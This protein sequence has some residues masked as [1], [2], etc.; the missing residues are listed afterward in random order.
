MT[1]K[2]NASALLSLLTVFVPLSAVAQSQELEQDPIKYFGIHGGINNVKSWDAQVDFGGPKVDAALVLDRGAHLGF[3]L[4]RKYT[5]ARY[6]LEYQYGRIEI[7]R[8][9]VA[10]LV[11][12]QSANGSYHVATVNALRYRPVNA[13]LSVYA[14]VGVGFAR[15]S[16]PDLSVASC[17]CLVESDRT[18]FAWQARVGAER[19]VSEKGFLIAQLGWLAIPGPRAKGSSGVSY[20]KKGFAT[21]NVGYRREY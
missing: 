7:D 17:K 2:K 20:E 12:G 5:R 8:A 13:E 19:R 14:G 11:Q 9:S 10:A 18:G 21:V 3:K 16:L 4:G 1:N 6:E 15:V